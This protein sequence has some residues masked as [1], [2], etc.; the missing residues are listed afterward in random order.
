MAHYSDN[1]HSNR[2][3]LTIES[4]PQKKAPSLRTR[5]AVIAVIVVLF[6]VIGVIAQISSG[7]LNFSLRDFVGASKFREAGMP[8]MARNGAK[9][10]VT[11]TTARTMHPQQTLT[12]TASPTPQPQRTYADRTSSEPREKSPA[13]DYF[14]Q[15]GRASCR[16]RV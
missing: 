14:T 11:P 4:P 3:V 15:I 13:K 6:G 2:N 16:E 9:E 1:T 7:D 10:Q 5:I 8:S 12:V